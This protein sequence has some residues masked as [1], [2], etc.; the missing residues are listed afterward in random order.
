[1]ET[2]ITYQ[3]IILYEVKHIWNSASQGMDRDAVCVSAIAMDH[4]IPKTLMGILFQF[5]SWGMSTTEYTTVN[6]GVLFI[7]T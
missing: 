6:Q 4:E 5:P 7:I 2:L 1:L 3:I